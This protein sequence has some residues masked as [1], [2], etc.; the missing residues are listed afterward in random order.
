MKKHLFIL[1]G[2][3]LA[4]AWV[5]AQPV[6][7]KVDEAL[8]KGKIMAAD[9]SKK[10]PIKAGGIVALNLNQQNSSYWVGANEK[11]ALNVGISTDLYLNADWN[12]NSWNNTLKLNYAWLNNESQGVR[13]TSDFIDLY[14]KYGRQVDKHEK[15][16]LAVI[17]NLRTQFTNGYDYNLDPRRRTSG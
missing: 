4:C 12:K 14:S 11:Y 7:K 16:F 8:A 13:K 5:M 6:P 15:L 3:A 17:G 2:C 9:T 1:T 10:G